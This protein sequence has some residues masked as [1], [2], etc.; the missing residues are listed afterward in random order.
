MHC[1][2]CNFAVAMRLTQKSESMLELIR[3]GKPMTTSD[4]LNL[5]VLL[6]IPSILAQI[7]SVVMFFIV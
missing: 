4:K 7:T 2:I 6:S 3:S 5:I 1:F